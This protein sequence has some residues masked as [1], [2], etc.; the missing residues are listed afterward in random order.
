MD[1]LTNLKIQKLLQEYSYLLSDDEYKLEVIDTYRSEF[2]KVVNEENK[3]EIKPEDKNEEIID[4]SVNEPIDV[5]ENIIKKCKKIYRE[6]VKL[7]HPD[8]TKSE[9]LVDLY[10]KSK[11]AYEEYNL[12]DLYLI[13]I[14]LDIN[15]TLEL[16]DIST[17]SKLID[18]KKEKLESIENSWLWL[19][20][21]SKTEEE[22]MNIVNKFID[23]NKEKL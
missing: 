17:L 4:K 19:W 9:W 15:V 10:I 21:N 13:S 16:E 7:T 1:K 22:K 6:I 23:K 5:P 12:F 8:K 20:A 18:R 3:T 2:L 11:E 14:K